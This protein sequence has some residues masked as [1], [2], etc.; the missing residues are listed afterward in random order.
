MVQ[1]KEVLSGPLLSGVQNW[2]ALVSSPAHTVG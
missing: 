2:S 1:I